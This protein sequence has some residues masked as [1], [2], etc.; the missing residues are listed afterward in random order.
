MLL[1]FS[2]K[3][4]I[5]ETVDSPNSLVTSIVNSA[6]LFINPDNADSPTPISLR[7]DSPVS[8]DVSTIEKPSTTTPS[9]GIFSP[10]FTTIIS[11]ILTSSG[12][13]TFI[14]DPTFK[15]AE[16]GLICISEV[17]DFLDFP[18]AILC[19]YSPIL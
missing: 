13:T 3:S 9:K 5:F 6:F 15:L 10:G 16:S 14:S 11:P 18:T 4:S 12:E 8:A 17:I 1:A 2:T 19:K 7:T